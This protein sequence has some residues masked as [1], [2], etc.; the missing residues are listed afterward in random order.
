MPI[1]KSHLNLLIYCLVT[2]GNAIGFGFFYG[3]T[4]TFANYYNVPED[5]INNTFYIGLVTEIIFCFPALKVIEWRLDYSIIA[6]AFLTMA[7]YWMQVVAQTSFLV[8]NKIN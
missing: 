6:G 5:Y 1:R 3:N 4:S 8:S 2:F 7:S